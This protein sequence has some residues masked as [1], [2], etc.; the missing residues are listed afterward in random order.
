MPHP[1]TT[2]RLHFPVNKLQMPYLQEFR[3]NLI[4]PREAPYANPFTVAA[5]YN[6]CKKKIHIDLININD[7]DRT[8]N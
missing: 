2:P 1:G 4:K 8:I 5:S 3:H 6:D 7:N